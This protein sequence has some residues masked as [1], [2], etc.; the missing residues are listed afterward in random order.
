MYFFELIS[1]L[2]RDETNYGRKKSLE[3]A[4]LKQELRNPAIMRWLFIATVE[5]L[6]PKT[7]NTC[8]PAIHNGQQMLSVTH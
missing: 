2:Y 3:E 4:I 1:L 6:F 5:L 8:C 7:I